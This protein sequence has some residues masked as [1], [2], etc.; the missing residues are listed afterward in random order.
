MPGM[1]PPVADEQEAL[2]AYLAQQRDG[3][4]I[5]VFG[6]DDE[7]AV[8]APSPSALCLA[9][10]VKHL[11][12]VERF[13]MG[14]VRGETPEGDSDQYQDSFRTGPDD[15]LPGL[16]DAYAEVAAETEETVRTLGDLGHPV[17]VP[18]GVPW[19]PSD[20]EAW[21][22]RWVLLHLIEETARHAGHA[23]IVREGV[24]RA[25]AFALMAAAEDWPDTPWLQ[26]W[27][28]PA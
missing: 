7:Q 20:V 9:G 10:I 28:P 23:D 22:L 3:V 8:E 26:K 27:A 2:V 19:F 15:T 11:T 18:P 21:S 6:L 13:W 17:P 1:V 5:A 24:D 16:L 14:L 12:G 25:T 4:R